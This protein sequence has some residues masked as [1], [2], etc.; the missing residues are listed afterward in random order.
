[1]IAY[2]HCK[3]N[4]GLRVLGRR[5]DGYHDLETV[6]FPVPL[7]DRLEILP[8]EEF[9]FSQTGIA[10]DCPTEENICVRAYR[11]LEADFATKL[12]PVQMVLHK[13]IPFGAGLGGGSSDAAF[14]LRMLNEMFS[15]GLNRDSLLGY[16]S[17]LGADCAFFLQDQP[18]FATGIGDCLTPVELNPEIANYQL[19]L[20]KPADKVST[21]EA[22]RNVV[23]LNTDSTALRQEVM[24]PLAMW[25]ERVDNSFEASVLPQHPRIAEL[26]A[27]M[28]RQGAV[29]AS[30]S[31]SGSTVYG[32][33][34]RE[35]E[36][37][38]LRERLG[39]EVIYC[40]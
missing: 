7:C 15:L 2:P 40:N 1:M 19:L 20:V 16:A 6:F 22:Y 33:F 10:I 26:K 5:A 35:V 23:V 30:M 34:P 29:Y 13:V 28:Y 11:M 9:G 38:G 37:R 17:R 21:G 27:M 12:Q 39:E 8:A 4:I 24:M 18:A 25:R 14:T 32:F 31:G 3:I 36:L